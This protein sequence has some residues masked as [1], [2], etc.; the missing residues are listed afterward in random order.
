[1]RAIAATIMSFGAIALS[2]GAVTLV[3]L[4]LAKMNSHP[5][6]AEMTTVGVM[7][8]LAGAGLLAVGYFMGRMGRREGARDTQTNR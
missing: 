1:M 2:F 3:L 6:L 5:G 7:S 8:A 4:L